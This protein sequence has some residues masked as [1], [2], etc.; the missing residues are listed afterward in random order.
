MP[1]KCNHN[2]T[3]NVA[4]NAE[5]VICLLNYLN[6]TLVSKSNSKI[7]LMSVSGVFILP[8]AVRSLVGFVILIL[9][10]QIIISQ[11]LKYHNIFKNQMHLDFCLYVVFQALD[12]TCVLFLNISPSEALWKWFACIC[13][14]LGSVTSPS[15]EKYLYKSVVISYNWEAFLLLGSLW[16]P[17]LSLNVKTSLVF[18]IQCQS[19][20]PVYSIL[21][22]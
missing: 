3:L 4:L 11:K 10:H 12:Y 7:V 6:S 5:V 9:L 1:V 20:P 16:S 18:T 22:S 17:F 8:T 15:G 13:I 14:A 2:A 21:L 19:T